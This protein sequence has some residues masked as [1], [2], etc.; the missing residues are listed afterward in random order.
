MVVEL[1]V[2][3]ASQSRRCCFAAEHALGETPLTERRVLPL[4]VVKGCNPGGVLPSNGGNFLAAKII[5]ARRQ[6]ASP[7]PIAGLGV[8]G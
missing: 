4:P 3:R 7:V 6:P 1:D 5:A 2:V 8:E